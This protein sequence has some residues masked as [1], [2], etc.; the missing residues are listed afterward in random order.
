ML[1]GAPQVELAGLLHKLQLILLEIEA[2][3]AFLI[4][5]VVWTVL[6]PA[7]DAEASG[8]CQRIADWCGEWCASPALT[9]LPL[10]ESYRSANSL[11]A[12]GH[13]ATTKR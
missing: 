4:D 10:S 7:M 2:P 11:C 3:S 1:G 8:E 12:T 5:L 6:V 13:P 9:S